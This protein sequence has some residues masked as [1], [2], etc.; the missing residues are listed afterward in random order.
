V[1]TQ[2]HEPVKCRTRHRL[3]RSNRQAHPDKGSRMSRT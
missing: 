3:I 1:E 2:E